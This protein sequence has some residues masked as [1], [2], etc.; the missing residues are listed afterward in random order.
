MSSS[1]HTGDLV[2]TGYPIRYVP[3][4]AIDTTRWD[5]CIDQAANSLLYGFHF[6]LDHMAAGQWD[7]LILGDY[8][9][10]MPLTW[11]RKY[12]IRYLYQ[13]PFTQQTGI[14]S[15]QPL[16]PGLIEA[17]IR[18]ARDHFRFAEIFLNYSNPHPGLQPRTN[19]ILSLDAPYAH[20]AAGYKKILA[21]SLRLAARASLRYTPDVDLEKALTTNHRQYAAR[22]PHVTANDHAH[23]RALCRDLQ[24]RGQ[25]VL[26][27]ATGPEDDHLLA[28]ALLFRDR[29][30]LYLLQSTTP[31]AGR[32]TE[33]NRFLLDGII[34]EFA[35]QPILLDFE[36]SDLP[37]VA[38]FYANFG[39]MRQP[40]FFYR[41]NDLPWPLKLLKR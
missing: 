41:Y 1:Q 22:T 27:A 9:A 18:T 8:E 34:R 7:A 23:F 5:A 16:S 28:T 6:Y 36:G 33:A 12:G 19:Y 2:R 26:R 31:K 38:Q 3:R 30:R 17:F 15:P 11:R 37:G 10:V 32:K 24:T 40:Y 29:R 14:F 13:P 35:T 25:L 21:Y 20:I 4:H 39:A